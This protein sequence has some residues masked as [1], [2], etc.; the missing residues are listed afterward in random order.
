VRAALNALDRLE[1]VQR[2]QVTQRRSAVPM[3]PEQVMRVQ[4]RALL[5]QIQG[6]RGPV[7]SV[8]AVGGAR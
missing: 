2:E 1:A 7:L 8:P 4:G 3:A 5:E 6:T